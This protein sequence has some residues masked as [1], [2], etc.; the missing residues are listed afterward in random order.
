MYKKKT[1]RFIVS[2][3]AVIL[4]AAMV[5]PTVLSLMM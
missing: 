2:I 3:V 5:I 4:I 1:Q